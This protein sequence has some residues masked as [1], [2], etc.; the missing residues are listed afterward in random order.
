M[1]SEGTFHEG[2][3]LFITFLELG[4][5]IIPDENIIQIFFTESI[6][7]HCRLTIVHFAFLAHHYDTITFIILITAIILL[8]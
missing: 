3:V 2:S 7:R 5:H 4:G 6:P 1:S 8:L